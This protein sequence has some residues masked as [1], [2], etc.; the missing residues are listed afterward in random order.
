VRPSNH[1]STSSGQRSP[2]T[3]DPNGA[4]APYLD[5]HCARLSSKTGGTIAK[6]FT[7]GADPAGK[8]TL[9]AW[10]ARRMGTP[11]ADLGDPQVLRATRHGQTGCHWCQ[12]DCRHYHWVGVDY[13]PSG[14]DLFLDDFE[15]TYA[16]FAMLGL[17]P[18]EDTFQARLDLRDEVD[19]RLLL[20]IEQ[21][22]CDTMNVGLGLAALFEGIERGLIPATDF[23]PALV[24]RA[25]A[26]RLEAAVQGV[27]MLCSGQAFEYPAL[28]AVDL[29]DALLP[30]LRPLRRTTIQDRRDTS[31][32]RL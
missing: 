2:F 1:P 15:P 7:T 25:G 28:R 9:P 18:T 16:T 31:P 6:L 29:S 4:I 17:E 11:L 14:R 21:M 22:G 19:R 27:A 24:G 23:P 10:N 12:V 13:A 32:T 3:R 30:F 20:P 8:N 5:K 26:G